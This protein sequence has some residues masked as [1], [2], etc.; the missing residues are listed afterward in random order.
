MSDRGLQPKVTWLFLSQL[1]ALC[2]SSCL[3]GAFV[4]TTVSGEEQFIELPWLGLQSSH[5]DGSL[6]TNSLLPF[7]VFGFCSFCWECHSCSGIIVNTQP[8]RFSDTVL[9]QLD[10]IFAAENHVQSSIKG[11]CT[12]KSSFLHTELV[13]TYLFPPYF[14]QCQGIPHPTHFELLALC[15][16]LAHCR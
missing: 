6:N 8:T 3:Q 16:F 7:C 5:T 1:V 2:L 13:F 10:M 12:C 9:G 4:P 11:L 14:K 15:T